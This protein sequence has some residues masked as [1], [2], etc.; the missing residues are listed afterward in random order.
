MS[1][2]VADSLSPAIAFVM[3]MPR[4]CWWLVVVYTHTEVIEEWLLTFLETRRLVYIPRLNFV[5]EPEICEQ[6]RFRRLPWYLEAIEVFGR[7]DTTRV[8]RM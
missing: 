3:S 8:T 6:T 7:S 1:C 5:R 4:S 2:D